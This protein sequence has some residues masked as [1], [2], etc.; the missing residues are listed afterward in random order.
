MLGDARRLAAGAI[1]CSGVTIAACLLIVPLIHSQLDAWTTRVQ[2]QMRLFKVPFPGLFV[3]GVAATD[4]IR[5]GRSARTTPG[6]R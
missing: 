4:E 6:S 5:L 1:A 2:L 3:S